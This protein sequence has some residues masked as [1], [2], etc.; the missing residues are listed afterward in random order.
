METLREETSTAPRDNPSSS[1]RLPAAL[2]ECR[3]GL[4]I[5]QLGHRHV[6]ASGRVLSSARR[7]NGD[8][9]ESLG[10]TR[11]TWDLF[12]QRMKSTNVH[13]PSSACSNHQ[14]STNIPRLKKRTVQEL[15]APTQK[16]AHHGCAIANP[17]LPCGE[18]ILHSTHDPRLPLGLTSE[19]QTSPECA[20]ERYACRER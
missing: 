17:T 15:G 19:G 2:G 20:W 6:A 8:N 3:D 14:S 12:R 7:T 18:L 13:R 5:D 4:V 10:V 11:S 9:S 16:S 1:P